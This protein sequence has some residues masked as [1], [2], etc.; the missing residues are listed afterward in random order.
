MA[1]FLEIE[2]KDGCQPQAAIGVASVTII[3]RK[4]LGL[5][6]IAVPVFNLPPAPGEPARFGF[7]VVGV[8]V[9]ID[10]ALDPGD[11]YRIIAEVRNATQVADMLASTVTLWG[12]P[13]DPRHDNSRGWECTNRLSDEELPPCERPDGL[14]EAAFLRQP[15]SCA[16]PLDFDA[17]IEPWN[18][19]LGSVVDSATFDGGTMHGC[20]QVPFDPSIEA[21]PTSKLAEA[22]SGLSFNLSMPNSGLLNKDAIAEGQPKKVEV[23][24]PEG[25]TVNPSAAE[26]LAVC[27]PS[28]YARERSNSRPGEGCPDASKIGNVEIQTPLISETVKGALYQ[29]APYDNPANSLL[30]LYIVARSPERGVLVK[31]DGKV[32]PDPK[33]GQLITTFDDA[34]QLPF[35]SFDLNFR[36]GGRAPLVTPPACGDY[37]VVAKFTPWSAKDPDNPA[38]NEVVTRKS[39]FTVQRGVDGGACPSGG[40][41]PFNPGFEAGSLNND[42]KSYSPFYMRLTRRDGEQ[43]MTKFS[44]VLPPGV[45]GKLAGVAKCPDAAV[46]AAKSKTGTE[47]LGEPELPAW[48]SDRPRIHRRRSRLGPH[49]RR[50]LSLPRRPLQRRSAERDRGSARGRRSLRRR[51]G[52]C[53]RGADPEPRDRRSR[54]RRSGLGPDPPHPRRDPAQGA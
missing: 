7:T 50:R 31:L 14:G 51:H 1:D 48:L 15:V 54:S 17:Q 25:M 29:A 19:P 36:E 5:T 3:E 43:N 38:A 45:L 4:V 10:T 28:D 21:A 18:V 39:T 24:L 37:D 49:L 22:P 30:A 11:G 40:V 47:E 26:G 41:P 12:S 34:P 42:A 32:S 8:P 16:T 33:T 13:A 46:E 27:T 2:P 6:R 53:P 44:S 9:L 23:T 20:N 52:G 35:S